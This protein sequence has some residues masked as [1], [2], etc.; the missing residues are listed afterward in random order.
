MRISRLSEEIE[1]DTILFVP[2]TLSKWPSY[3][4]FNY[5]QHKNISLY[6]FDTR[7]NNRSL[8]SGNVELHSLE[9]FLRD[10]TNKTYNDLKGNTTKAVWVVFSYY[11]KSLKYLNAV[12][13][14]FE[15]IKNNENL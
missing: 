12:G 4:Y 5:T 1:S 15:E 11:S 2:I 14:Q 3:Y 6:W 10:P 7:T 9:F 8:E 13:I